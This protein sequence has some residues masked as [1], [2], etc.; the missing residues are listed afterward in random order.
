MKVNGMK[1][2]IR[3]MDRVFKSGLMV[4]FMR[5]IGETIKLTEEED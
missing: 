5:D 2:P 3:E 1:N 4:P